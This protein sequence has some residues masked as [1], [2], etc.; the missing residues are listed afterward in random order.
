MLKVALDAMGGDKAPGEIV[1][2]AVMAAEASEGRY[3]IV[4]T[5]PKELVGE[6]LAK[7][8]YK[9]DLIEVV[10]A[11]QLVAMDEHPAAV[12][13]TKP[14][15]GLVKCV[16]LQKAG[17]VQASV[18]AGNSGAMM[19]SSM[20]LLG[21][22]PA[23]SRPAIAA[24]L[25][26][27]GEPVLMLDCGANVDNK[28]QQ[29]VDWAHCGAVYAEAVMGRKNPRVA[30]LNIGE[31]EKKGPELEQTVH[32]MLKQTK[33]NFV[34]NAEP[35]EVL[36]GKNLDVVVTGGFSGNLLLKAIEAFFYLHQKAFGDVDTPAGRDFNA[37][38]DY[39]KQGAALLLGLQGTA[40]IAHGRAEA[41]AIKAAVE[42]AWRFANGDVSRKIAELMAAD[43]QPQA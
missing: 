41:P 8:G 6:E 19:A 30:L 5:G 15:S 7:A 33:L 18:S 32:Q 3:S 35:G 27:M 36:R 13:K 1:R 29:L 43:A 20:M 28:P 23:V 14:D 39:D 24:E 42:A 10:D 12:L 37:R 25:P 31:E 22:I 26:T 9:G 11:P 21:R 4:L 2:G 17:L 16:A 38:W 34:G 40:L